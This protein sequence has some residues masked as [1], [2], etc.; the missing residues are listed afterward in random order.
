MIGSPLPPK[1]WNY[2]TGYSWIHSLEDKFA[3]NKYLETKQISKEQMDKDTKEAGIVIS[4]IWSKDDPKPGITYAASQM[5]HKI[6]RIAHKLV[7][8][9]TK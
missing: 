5:S 2:D 7:K 3:M 9:K 8:S 1:A 4:P 6:K